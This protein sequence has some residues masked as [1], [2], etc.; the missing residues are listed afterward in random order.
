MAYFSIL[1]K[2]HLVTL[3]LKSII[4]L[5]VGQTLFFKF[6]GAEESVYI[7]STLGVEPW[8]RIALGCL[9]LFSLLLLWIPRTYLYALVLVLG[10]MLGAIGSH[11]LIL[12]IEIKGD[13][14]EL[15]ILALVTVTSTAV[16]LY[17]DRTRVV[18]EIDNWL[19][20]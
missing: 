19:G 11:L 3:V 4:T 7:F 8:G 1:M 18:L 15:F 20:R 12:G 13:G 5:I 16:L 9:E 17:L 10:M 6:S 14:G 2:Q